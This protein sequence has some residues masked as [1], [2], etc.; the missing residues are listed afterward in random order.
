MAIT[1]KTQ[2]KNPDGVTAQVPNYFFFYFKSTQTFQVIKTELPLDPCRKNPVPYISHIKITS[3]FKARGAFFKLHGLYLQTHLRKPF[4]KSIVLWM[5]SENTLP[6]FIYG[7]L[8]GVPTCWNA[9][10]C[11]SA[12]SWQMINYKKPNACLPSCKKKIKYMYMYVK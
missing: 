5:T 1:A 9:T 8:I 10:F 7:Q 12:K 3:C 11:G 6:A 4:G 2:A